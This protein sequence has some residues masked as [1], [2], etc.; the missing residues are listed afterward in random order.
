LLL[1]S[2]SLSQRLGLL[3]VVSLAAA[4]VFAVGCGDGGFGAEPKPTL[5][6]TSVPPTFVR[7]TVTPNPTDT[8][9]P[10]PLPTATSESFEVDTGEPVFPLDLDPELVEERP[11]DAV[12]FEGWTRY[13]T[14]TSVVNSRATEGSSLHL[15]ADGRIMTEDGPHQTIQNWRI[16]RSPAISFLDWG[17]VAVHVDVVAGRWQGRDWDV[18]ALVR[19]TGKV[20]VTNN[21]N[22]GEAIIERSEI[23]LAS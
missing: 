12:I 17:T 13:L 19:R 20:F 1:F 14:N 7:I 11:E 21:P 6:A 9:T 18:M 16:L 5:A 2:D 22:P 23:C 3:V 10:T 8:P 4:F 15:C